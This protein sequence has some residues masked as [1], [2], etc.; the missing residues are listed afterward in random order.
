MDAEARQILNPTDSLLVAKPYYS[1]F[2]LAHDSYNAISSISD[3]QIYYVLS[4]DSIDEGGKMY[5][6]NP[7]TDQIKYL[8]DLTE[9]CREKGKKAISQ[10]KSHVD[11]YEYNGKLYFVTHVGFYEMIDGIERLPKNPPEGYSLYPGGH[12]LSYD[13]ETGE[14]EDLAIVPNEGIVTMAMDTKRGHVYG[15]TWPGGNFVHYDVNRKE[16][17]NI[18]PVSGK[19]EAGIPGS[20]YRVLCRSLFVDPDEGFVYFSTAEGDIFKYGPDLKALQKVEG[21]NLRLDY[22]GKYDFRQPGSMGYNWRK[23]IWYPSEGAAYGVHGNSGY[24]FRFDPKT[25]SLDIVERITSD[26]S[27][28]SGMFDQ[29]T[30]G[31][32]GL[33][34]GP[35]G[36]TLYYLTGGP[37]YDKG[38]RIEGEDHILVGAKG[39]EN[40]HLV[41]YN[42]PNRKYIDHGPI[43]YDDGTRPTYVNSIAIDKNGNVY[44]LA[45]FEQDGK[46]I[47]DLVKIPKPF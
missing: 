3:G 43:F 17:K 18:G 19:G 6:Y 11:F 35:D 42:I 46:V 37:I 47:A 12:V 28:R 38:K 15:I 4:S 34:L 39:L 5:V 13:L 9:I 32:L 27:R 40:L 23:I 45:R 29:F 2:T 16:L 24:L 36:H 26:P 31:Y 22:F 41:T 10:G 1:G 7:I 30:F 20:T 25:S 14:F 8:G 21:V 44:T 33:Q